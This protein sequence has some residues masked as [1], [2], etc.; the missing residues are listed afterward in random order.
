MPPKD[1]DILQKLDELF[2]RSKREGLTRLDGVRI[3]LYGLILALHLLILRSAVL[4]PMETMVLDFFFRQRQ[5]LAT[6]PAIAVIEINAESLQ[7]IGPWPWPWKYHAQMIQTLKDWGAKSIVYDMVFRDPADEQDAITLGKSLEESDRTFLAVDF[8]PKAEKKIWVHALPV[9]LEPGSEEKIWAHSPLNL[10]KHA[11]GLGHRDVEIDRDGILRKAKPFLSSHA[12]TYPYL[13]LRVAY[14]FLN[15]PFP[16]PEAFPIP[17]DRTGDFLIAW[18][19]KWEKTFRHYSYADLIRSSQALTQGLQPVVSPEDFKDK[20]CLIGLTAPGA[21]EFKVTPL[22][23]NF[24]V[25]GVQAE[26]LSSLLTGQFI[27]PVS[28]KMH[29]LL[30]AGL[31]VMAYVLFVTFRHVASFMAGLLAGVAW[32]G[33]SFYLFSQKGIW[34]FV[35]QP[36]LLILILFIFSVIYDLVVERKERTRLID[37]A[38]RDGLTGLYVI[39]HFRE[40]LNRMV[41]EAYRKKEPLSLILIDI[42][43]FKPI[44]DTYGHTAGDMVLKQTAQL[45]YSCFRSERPFHEADFVARYGG[46]EFIVMLR[47]APLK[48]AGEK[49]A[50][51]IRKKVHEHIFEWEGKAIPVTISLGVATLHPEESLP[52]LM[53]RRADDALYQAKRAGKNRVCTERGSEG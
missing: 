15:K 39:R 13:A 28:L 17:L 33:I 53:V 7:A 49:V 42:D 18:S 2:V 32:L 41:L 27:R 35:F 19:G 46:E 25:L 16:D 22:D 8:E 14:D 29:M 48:E 45:I 26:V 23:S 10:E 21:A 40:I 50:E 6:H 24:P 37:L 20:I 4:E 11:R 30:F 31:T 9:V 5:V 51:R 3:F 38:T 44:N 12:E 36:S 52:D 47:K 43:N 1:P 34:L